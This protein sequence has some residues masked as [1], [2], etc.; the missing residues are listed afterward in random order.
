[1]RGFEPRLF[2]YGPRE[3]LSLVELREALTKAH[4]Q[5]ERDVTSETRTRRAIREGSFAS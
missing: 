2:P 3:R 4:S 1:M 5:I